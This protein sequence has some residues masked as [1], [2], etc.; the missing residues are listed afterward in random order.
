MTD[1]R[2]IQ[3]AETAK[4]VRS[5]LRESFPDTKFSVRSE[6]YSMG[7]A[8]RIG[9]QDGPCEP[10]IDAL[11]N[12]F[13]GAY[14]DGGIDYQGCQYATLDGEPVRFQSDFITCNRQYSDAF[15]SRILLTLSQKYA[16][17]LTL[18]D[19]KSGALENVRLADEYVGTLLHQERYRRTRVVAKE[20]ATLKR[21]QSAGDDGY[22]R[23]TVG[24]GQ[25]GETAYTEEDAAKA[26]Y[27]SADARALKLFPPKIH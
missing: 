7:A 18:E 26:R 14:F 15:L 20:S 1:R 24:T 5:V 2:Y 8:I 25:G 9:W 19:Y 6:S 11:V 27:Q 16:R 10:Q 22:G 23:G 21:V 13:K 12:P 3:V 4:L 17:Q